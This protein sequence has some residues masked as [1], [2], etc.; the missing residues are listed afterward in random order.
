[1]ND[2]MMTTALRNAVFALIRDCGALI[3]SAHD[4]ERARG[5][6][7]DKAGAANY[8]TVYDVKVQEK[9][10]AGLSVLFPGAQFFAEEKENAPGLLENG[11]CF[12][13][14]PID[15]T[16]NFIHEMHCSAISVG[17]YD[18]K[19]PVFG[20]VY[21]PYL[22]EMFWAVRGEG[23][24]LNDRPIGVA[25]RPLEKALVSFGSSPYNRR[26]FGDGFFKQL[27]RVFLATA[28]IRRGGSAALDL[29]FVAAGRTDAFFEQ[30]LSPWD[31]AAG[32]LILREAGGVITDLR[33]QPLKIGEKTSVLAANA[34][35]HKEMLSLLGD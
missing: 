29:C 2:F 7:T 11:L 16:T 19:E 1:M 17:L 24:F 22:D 3:R 9:L 30:V 5:A 31:Y 18:R 13:I 15:G 32:Y 35:L 28:D 23:A 10:I 26:E 6:I 4:I 20:A 21:D 27:Y 33:G 14:D 12:I 25:D 34:V 8:V